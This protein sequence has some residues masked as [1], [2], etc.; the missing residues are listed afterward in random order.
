MLSD[1]GLRGNMLIYCLFQMSNICLAVLG[2]MTFVL[3][4]Y[5]MVITSQ[6]GVLNLLF[7]IFGIILMILSYFGCKLKNA[8]YGNLIYSIILSAIFIFD[9]AI[10]ITSFIDRDLTIDYVLKNSEVDE[11]SRRQ[12]KI[13]LTRNLKIVNELL[14]VIVVI[15]VRF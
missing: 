1:K 5:L 11:N 2:F 4:I 8:P 9:L 13:L 14:L 12:I 7:M 6:F 10:T 3:S 15:L